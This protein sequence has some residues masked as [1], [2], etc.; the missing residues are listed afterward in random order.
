MD[1][2]TI[3]FLDYVQR[4]ASK[5]GFDGLRNESYRKPSAKAVSFDA[6]QDL[7]PLVVEPADSVTI[8]PAVLPVEQYITTTA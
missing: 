7:H 6:E 3:K 1:A 8:E 5:N 2:D 4:W